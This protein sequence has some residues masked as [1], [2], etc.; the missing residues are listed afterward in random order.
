MPLEAQHVERRASAGAAAKREDRPIRPA[1]ANDARDFIRDS[2]CEAHASDKQTL[3][4][5]A[6]TSIT[7][8]GENNIEF[9]PHS[10]EP[11]IQQN[12]GLEDW[13]QRQANAGKIAFVRFTSSEQDGNEIG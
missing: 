3:T 4:E 6:I 7:K 1:A 5:L 12:E 10:E 8:T 11:H 2:D 9:I 13:C